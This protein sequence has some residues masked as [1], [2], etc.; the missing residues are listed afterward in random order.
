[1]VTATTYTQVYFWSY[2]LEPK[3]FVYVISTLSL[4][5]G[6]NLKSPTNTIEIRFKHVS[7]HGECLGLAACMQHRRQY[8][9]CQI[10]R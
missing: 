8:Y 4:I 3:Q 2:V 5:L 9:C 7:G 1:M 6:N 10:T